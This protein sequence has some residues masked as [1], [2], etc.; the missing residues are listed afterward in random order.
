MKK[1]R[2]N[3]F[4]I[5]SYRIEGKRQKHLFRAPTTSVYKDKAC[6]DLFRQKGC[7]IESGFTDIFGAIGRLG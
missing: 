3:N 4:F 5:V 2:I 7:K 6:R 1:R